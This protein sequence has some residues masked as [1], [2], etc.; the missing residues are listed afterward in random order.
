MSKVQGRYWE[1]AVLS[2]DFKKMG[3]VDRVPRAGN[4]Y[5]GGLHALYQK[6]ELFK[7]HQISHIVSVLDYDIH[8][9]GQFAEYKHYML[10]VDDDPN[11]DLLKHFHATNK[12]IDEA[13]Q[14]G[15]AVFV[16]CAMGKSRS[17]TIVCAYLMWK[18]GVTAKKALSQLC[19][20][21]PVCSPNPGFN[22]QLQVY[23]RMLQSKEDEA[24]V[25]KIYQD[26]DKHRFRGNAWEWHKRKAGNL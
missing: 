17:A 10:Q 3:W 25:A 15:G 8:G 20:G 21:R 9:N 7:E 12:F 6:P 11:E 16:H 22:E 14:G 18:Y 13:L 24:E 26:W 5:I 19:E 4:L 23:W 1:F 2:D